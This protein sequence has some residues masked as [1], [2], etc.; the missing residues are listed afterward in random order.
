[1]KI[2]KEKND[3]ICP[4]KERRKKMKTPMKKKME[5]KKRKKN[6]EKHWYKNGIFLKHEIK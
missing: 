5:K 3:D 6:N 1:M 2:S 4:T